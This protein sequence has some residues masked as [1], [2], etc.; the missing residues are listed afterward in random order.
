[1]AQTKRLSE[2]Q[3]ANIAKIE[4]EQQGLWN[5]L[6]AEWKKAVQPLCEKLEKANVDANSMFPE[7]DLSRWKDWTP[8][9]Q[10]QNAAK[11]GRLEVDVEK[12]A[13]TGNDI[14]AGSPKPPT[15]TKT[16]RL[17]LPCP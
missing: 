3:A 5:A 1:E 12:L 17:A 15:P 10:F 2:T 9:E 4:S 7:W 6:E 13:E 11:F 14:P 8:P 16:R